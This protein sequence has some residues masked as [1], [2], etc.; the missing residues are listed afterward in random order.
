MNLEEDKQLEQEEIIEMATIYKKETSR[1]L[2]NYQKQLNKAAQSLCLENPGLLCKKRSFLIETARQKII[3]KGFQF[4]KGKTRSKK[5]LGEVT[6]S[7]AKRRRLKTTQ[8]IRDRRIT[9]I[10]DKVTSL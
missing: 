3:D 2:T 4:K 10:E 1:P 8:E 7:P 5:G 6:D 9:E